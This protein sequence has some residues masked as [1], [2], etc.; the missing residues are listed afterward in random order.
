MALFWMFRR[1]GHW[2]NSALHP[3]F[4]VF[5]WTLSIL[6]QKSLSL[7]LSHTHTHTHTLSLS[8][9]HTQ[10]ISL[11][12]T[13]THTVYLW[14]G[15]VIGV[16]SG[17]HS[18]RLIQLIYCTLIKPS[19]THTHKQSN[20]T[21]HKQHS[22]ECTVLKSRRTKASR[23]PDERASVPSANRRNM[24][25]PARESQFKVYITFLLLLLFCI[26]VL[27]HIMTK[28]A[29]CYFESQQRCLQ[30]GCCDSCV[31]FRTCCIPASALLG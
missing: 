12:H 17:Q 25:L 1:R 23:E 5:I 4:G 9:S 31:V 27:L 16:T 11:S 13:H 8:F 10:T 22:L 6:L 14:I 2:P 26:N 3:L 24:S 18:E 15:T 19:H 30:M 29:W 21:Q 28:E 20:T 7:S